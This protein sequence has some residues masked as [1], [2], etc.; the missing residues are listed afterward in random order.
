MKRR[1]RFF[2]AGAFLA[3]LAAL[4]SA[5][6]QTNM[7]I[8]SN[9]LQNG[10]A[11]WSWSSAINFACANPVPPGDSDSISVTSDAWGALFLNVSGT[12]EID[13][14]LFT[15]LVFSLNGGPMGGQVLTV[16]PPSVRQGKGTS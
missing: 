6:A 5:R 16:M 12:A 15:N 8:Y 13:S 10:W 4:S 11:N 2:A 7:L 1:H 3:A 14:S 9:A